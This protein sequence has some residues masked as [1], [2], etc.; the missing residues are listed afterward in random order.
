MIELIF[1]FICLVALEVIFE[2]D[3]ITALKRKVKTL[4]QTALCQGQAPHLLALCVRIAL[5]SILYYSLARIAGSAHYQAATP[6]AHLALKMFG[7]LAI[8][9][10]GLALLIGAPQTIHNARPIHSGTRNLK[11]AKGTLLG[12]LFAD[13]LLSLDSV[14]AT[15]A[16]TNNFK[17]A[18]EAMASAAIII[19]VFHKQINAWLK[20]N[21]RV[22]ML[23]YLL[24]IMLGANLT[25][26]A[27][28][29]HIPKLLLLMLAAIA[30]WANSLD[31]KPLKKLQG[32][33]RKGFYRPETVPSTDNDTGRTLPEPAVGTAATAA[34]T[35]AKTATAT[36]AKTA[37]ATA[38]AI[39]PAAAALT[40]ALRA[41]VATV[42]VPSPL[43]NEFYTFGTTHQ[44]GLSTSA[45]SSIG[46]GQ[47]TTAICHNCGAPTIAGVSV[48][49]GCKSYS[50]LLPARGMEIGALNSLTGKKE[51]S[52]LA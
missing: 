22:I 42:G 11:A 28:G 13:A 36:A 25:A 7:G 8:A 44:A 47:N 48:C 20:T 2:I 41:Q 3:N 35:A 17:L 33:N 31:K 24:I 50:Y 16:M 29:L 12:F 18:V 37:A 43:K 32:A 45:D 39:A 14:L 10:I 38:T 1:L 49:A 21:P 34:A 23:A 27:F 46:F 52:E 30:I 4:P 6:A 9:S 51:P 40:A 5:A 15:V 19:M 26:D